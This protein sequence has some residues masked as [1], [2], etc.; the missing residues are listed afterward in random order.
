MRE[1]LHFLVARTD[2]WP[3]AP[4]RRIRRPMSICNSETRTG[5]REVPHTQVTAARFTPMGW[6]VEATQCLLTDAWKS[7]MWASH[8]WEYY[9]ALKR[10]ECLT[11]ATRWMGPEGIMVG[12]KEGRSPKAKYCLI[13]LLEAHSAVKFRE[14]EGTMLA[15]RSLGERN[16]NLCLVGAEFPFPTT[17]TSREGFTTFRTLGNS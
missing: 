2:A 1:E 17:K 8:L 4:D 10:S 9:S 16:G 3:D 15:A 13:P 5:K 7:E 12:I 6:G 11:Q 14:T